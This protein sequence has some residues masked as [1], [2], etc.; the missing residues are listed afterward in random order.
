M[1]TSEKLLKTYPIISEQI[2][3]DE[4]EVIL[5]ELEK[6]IAQGLAG[7]IVEFGCYCGTTSL[8][9]QR[10]IQELVPNKKLWVYDSFDG[11]PEKTK[12]DQSPIGELFVRGQ[13][14]ATKSQ[15]IQ[16]FRKAHL[17]LPSITKKWFHEVEESELPDKICFAFLDGDYY[18]SIRSSLSLVMPRMVKGGIIIIDDY[19]NPKLPGPQKAVQ[20]AGIEIG[21]VKQSLGIYRVT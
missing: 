5:C 13:L 21:A 11:L 6:I 18:I 14:R 15:F 2:E 17:T 20:D 9:L 1:T 16:N 7:D 10:M 4:L 19:D 12:E 8:F 3:S